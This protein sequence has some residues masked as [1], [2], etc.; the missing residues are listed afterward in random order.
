M[1]VPSGIV[2]QTEIAA[3]VAAVEREL[4]PD[5]VRI[6][7]DIGPDWSDE[8]SIFFRILLSDDASCEERLAEVTQRVASRLSDGLKLGEL[9]LLPYFNFRSQSEQRILH[10]EAWA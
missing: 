3:G 2:K 9:G 8:W 7:Y 4:A 10:K 6:R 5:V 1:R